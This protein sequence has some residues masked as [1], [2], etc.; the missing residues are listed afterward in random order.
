M[1][2]A[3]AVSMIWTMMGEKWQAQ[4]NRDTKGSWGGE[5]GG[6]GQKRGGYIYKIKGGPQPVE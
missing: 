5:K 6:K 4:W 3:E 1:S 2:R